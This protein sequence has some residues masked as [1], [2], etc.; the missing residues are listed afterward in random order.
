MVRVAINGFGRIGRMVFRAGFSHKDIEFVA[1]ND[2]TGT[3]T[4]AHLLKYDSVHGKLSADVGHDENNLYINGKQLRVYAQRDPKNLPW[5][6]LGVDVV[7]ES[8]GFFTTKEGASGHL[9]AGAQKVIISAPAK[10]DVKTVII[11]INEGEITS[12]DRV[13]SN[14]SCTSNSLAPLVK[15]L[16]DNFGIVHGFFST[17]H[18]YTGDQRIVDGPHKDLRRARAAAQNIVPTSSGA[19]SAVTKALPELEGKITGMAFRVPVPDGSV[20]EFTCVVKK[21][22]DAQHINW[23][24]SQVAHHHL[25]DVIRYSDEP[26]VSTDIIGDTHSCIFDAQSTEVIDG[27]LV[28]VVGWYDNEW[29]YSNR[30][31][32]LIRLVQK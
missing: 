9:D 14:A 15:V 10:G 22:T 21:K 24:F 8:T 19:A 11:G 12:D 3:K 6:D 20:T 27:H 17:V 16:H 5:K 26:L 4:L 28:R 7:I 18:A 29:G 30:L 23:L 13:L 25:R 31:I 32:D 2:L 1:V